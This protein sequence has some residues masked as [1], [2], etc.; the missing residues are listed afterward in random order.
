MFNV[1]A[2]SF[3][4][5]HLKKD[6]VWS[7]EPDYRALQSVAATADY[8]TGRING[9]A[10]FELALNMKT[11]V[12]YDTVHHGDREERVVNQDET[13]AAREKQ[14][15]LKEKFK[16]W[17]FADPDRTERLVR[18]YND[19]YNNLRPR[20]FDGSHLDFPGMNKTIEM[21]PHQVDA[22]WRSMSSGNTLLA[23]EVGLGKTY[24]MM[25]AAMKMK[26]AGLISKPLLVVPNHLLDDMGREWRK[27]YPNAKLLIANKEDFTKERRKAAYGQ[28]R[29]RRLGRHHRH[30]FEF[31]A[32]RHVAGLSGEV[33]ARADRRI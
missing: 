10:L 24:E 28:D 21:K 13:Q 19:T 12:I 27:L 29:H 4:V 25:A 9:T 32:D 20:L 8:G 7:V 1:P 33:P 6:A 17:I 5:G 18:D 30:P 31:R 3:N 26:Q 11:P 15:A 2:E 16:A 22:V 14:R 23:H